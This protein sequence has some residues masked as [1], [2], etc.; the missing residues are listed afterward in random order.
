MRK[1]IKAVAVPVVLVT[2]IAG[3]AGYRAQD[4]G[5]GRRLDELSKERPAAAT[6]FPIDGVLAAATQAA[7]EARWI[8][9]SNARQTELFFQAAAENEALE[10]QRAQSRKAPARTGRGGGGGGS[11]NP[12]SI[13]QRESK[14]DPNAV[15]RARARAASTSSS[16]ARGP[17]T[18]ATRGRR[19][20]PSPSRT[21]G[22][23]RC[24]PA[25]PVPRTGAAERSLDTRCVS[26]SGPGPGTCRTSRM[27]TPRAAPGPGFSIPKWR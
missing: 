19:T 15:N 11:C 6:L 7:E 21:S 23:T 9:G 2:A 22:S 18:A 10:A 1:P 24:G 20:P 25:A 12:E 27:A 16:R 17:A 5:S 8:E 3:A 13:V 14:G 26:R 4:S